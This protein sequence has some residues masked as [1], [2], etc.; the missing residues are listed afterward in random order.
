MVREV[1]DEAEY[2]KSAVSDDRDDEDYDEYGED[3]AWW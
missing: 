3:D 2:Y 1:E